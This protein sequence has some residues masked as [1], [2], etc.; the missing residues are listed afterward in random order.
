MFHALLAAEL[1]AGWDLFVELANEADESEAKKNSRSGCTE[2]R[3]TWS[4]R[5]AW[6]RGSLSTR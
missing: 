2:R 5:H 3:S 6:S 1:V 4:S